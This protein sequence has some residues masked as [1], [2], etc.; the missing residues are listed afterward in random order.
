M[1]I[2][3][4]IVMSEWSVLSPLGMLRSSEILVRILFTIHLWLENTQNA[5]ISYKIPFY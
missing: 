2:A 4:V 5:K 1:V 3:G